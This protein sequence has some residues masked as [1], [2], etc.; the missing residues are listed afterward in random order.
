MIYS[1]SV[2]GVEWRPISGQFWKLAQICKKSVQVSPSMHFERDYLT[3][4]LE[5][6]NRN[7]PIY[8]I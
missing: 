1:S 4:I 2:E 7:L 8:V 6:T 5:R 3:E